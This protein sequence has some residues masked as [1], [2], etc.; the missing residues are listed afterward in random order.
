M[1]APNGG[2]NWS[3]S[4]IQTITWNTT[5]TVGNVDIRFSTDGGVNWTLVRDINNSTASNI[6]NTGSFEWL[7]PST[8]LATNCMIQI[9]QRSG[10]CIVDYND[11]F[12]TIDDVPSITVT[13][14]KGG[15]ILYVDR[16][17]YINWSASNLTTNYVAIDYSTDDGQNWIELV[18][19][20]SSS[21]SYYWKIPNTLST[22]CLVRVRAVDDASVFSVSPANF[23]IAQP[24]IDIT[25]IVGGETIPGCT[26]H[27]VTWNQ[28]GVSPYVKIFYSVDGGQSWIHIASP[29]IRAT[30]NGTYDWTVPSMASSQFKIKVEDNDNSAVECISVNFSVSVG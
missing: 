9:Q 18:D 29:Y 16:N 21:G 2:E 23:T 10:N 28:E 15:E 25:S 1:T 20:R 7:V 17:Y 14:P 26:T 30:S 22:E 13:S 12:F 3:A 24:T 6:S 27:K 4:S 19:S 5:G 8:A 11:S